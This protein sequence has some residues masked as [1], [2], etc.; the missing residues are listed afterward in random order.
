MTEWTTVVKL[1]LARLTGYTGTEI[2]YN[3]V[4]FKTFRSN[5]WQVVEFKQDNYSKAYV[6]LNL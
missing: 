1:Q 4:T 6:W 5:D 3:A 2:Q